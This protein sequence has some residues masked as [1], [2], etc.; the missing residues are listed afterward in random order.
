[1]NQPTTSRT[2]YRRRVIDAEID[3]LQSGA[4]AIALEGAKA[5]G[6]TATAAQR[7]TTIF[8]LDRKEVR[9]V[10]SADPDRVLEADFPVLLDE[11]QYE[12]D[13]WNVVRRAVDSGA[14]PGS[15]FLTGSAG[16]E[17]TGT[18]SGSGRILRLRMRPLSLAERGIET[19]TVSLAALLEGNRP[20]IIGETEIGLKDYVREILS[21]GFPAIRELSERARRAQL[22]GYLA[23]VVDRD[24]PE[25]GHQIRNPTALQRWMAAYA[26]ATSTTA[27]FER[28]R[29]AATSGEGVK[30]ARTTA[31]PYR[32]T[33]ER[34]WIL[35]P[36]PAW[37]PTRNHLKELG[38]A[39]KHHLAD[40]A[41]A[42]Q[43]LGLNAR[44]LLLGEEITPAIYRD[45]TF[46]G[47][48]FESLVTLSV[49]VYAQNA[50]AKTA[51]LRLHRG[52]H[53]IDLIV[54]R[55]DQRVVALEVKLSATVQT[56]DVK[57]LVW[58]K[59]QIGPDLLDA[60]VITTGKYAYR[61]RE[62]GIAVIPAALLGP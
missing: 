40:P 60:A 45:G 9:E 3:A 58:L 17:P 12:P 4:A 48:L 62:D 26:A 21:S 1:M 55:P 6:K 25:L 20:E 39:P 5:V 28:I 7:S 30:P 34:L 42:T 52:E 2:P 57:H 24:F 15:F 50:E 8:E 37:I 54:T 32:D 11:W 49:R 43:L 47:A 29:D 13:L 27:S 44:A 35:D 38:E 53:E 41:L 18:H 36:L 19:P 56:E 23:R 10:L 46:L 51:H 22:D 33:L 61:R 59:D 31:Q 14:A 16:A